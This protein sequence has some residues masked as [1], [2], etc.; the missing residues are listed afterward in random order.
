[1]EIF[2]KP[3]RL[4]KARRRQTPPLRC[5]HPL[6]HMTAWDDAANAQSH[7]DPKVTSWPFGTGRTDLAATAPATCS[8]RERELQQQ[9]RVIPTG[10]A[11]Q[12]SPL[13]ANV[14]SLCCPQPHSCKWSE[15]KRSV[16]SGCQHVVSGNGPGSWAPNLA[17]S[18]REHR[19]LPMWSNNRP[20]SCRCVFTSRHHFDAR[21]MR[22]PSRRGRCS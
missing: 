9:G 22:S 20:C 4:G 10:L 18:R 15:P 19:P 11:L 13:A 12:P 21:P 14:M 6:L 3:S 16:L 2:S 8:E 1:M 7:L 5:S 17:S